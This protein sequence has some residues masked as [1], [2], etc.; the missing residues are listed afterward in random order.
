[1]KALENPSTS[2]KAPNAISS[3]IRMGSRLTSSDGA[4]AS[5]PTSSVVSCS[6]IASSMSSSVS[7]FQ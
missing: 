5:C 4:R 3:G 6:S 7:T 2:A 1:M